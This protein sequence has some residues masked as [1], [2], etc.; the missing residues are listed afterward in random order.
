MI[1]SIKSLSPR[2]TNYNQKDVAAAMRVS[3]LGSNYTETTN[4]IEEDD[5]S[6]PYFVE[7]IS[8]DSPVSMKMPPKQ[9][10]H[11][12]FSSYTSFIQEA[13]KVYDSF[14]PSRKSV[15]EDLENKYKLKSIMES[16]I[17]DGKAEVAKRTLKFGKP[18]KGKVV[19]SCPSS[20]TTQSEHK[21]Q[22]F[23]KK[24]ILLFRN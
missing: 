24:Y 1:V 6:F 22:R 17:Q 9:T 4:V 10:S 7:D 19:S 23:H 20:Q 3:G 2:L 15:Q 14:S 11:S 8:V 18:P 13:T 5:D 16:I 12:V 21:K